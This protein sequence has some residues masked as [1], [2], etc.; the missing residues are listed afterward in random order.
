MRNDT[1]AQCNELFQ[2]QRTLR[3]ID[4]LIDNPHIGNGMLS[5]ARERNDVIE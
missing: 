1:A 3:V 5:S 4:L 2:Q